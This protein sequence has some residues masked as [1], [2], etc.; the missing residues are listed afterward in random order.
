MICLPTLQIQVSW[1]VTVV[2]ALPADL[3]AVEGT[4]TILEG[5]V[6]G[7]L[8]LG[9]VDDTLPESVETFTV[10]LTSVTKGAELGSLLTATVSIDASDDLNGRFG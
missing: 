5:E 7:S 6:T 1:E 8:S 9:I 2:S 3:S 10:R 4:D